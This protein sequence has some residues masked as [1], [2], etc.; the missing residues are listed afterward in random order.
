MYNVSFYVRNKDFTYFWL[1][2]ICFSAIEMDGD[3]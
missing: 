1:T 2:M 3:L